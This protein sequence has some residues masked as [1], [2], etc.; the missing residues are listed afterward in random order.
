MTSKKDEGLQDPHSTTQ[1]EDIES[2]NK[3]ISLVHR[4]GMVIW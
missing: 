3:T 2:R 1:Q 4:G